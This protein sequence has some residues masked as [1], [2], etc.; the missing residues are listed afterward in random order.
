MSRAARDSFLKLNPVWMMKNPVMFVVEVGSVMTTF[1]LLRDVD[2]MGDEAELE[3]L[4]ERAAR[5]IRDGKL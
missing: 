1:L 5:E 4:A 3:E 2:D